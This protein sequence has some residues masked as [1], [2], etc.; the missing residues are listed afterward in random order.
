VDITNPRGVAVGF[1]D[2]I[3]V[4]AGSSSETTAIVR[5]DAESWRTV[6]SITYPFTGFVY[7]MAFDSDM[8]EEP[9]IIAADVRVGCSQSNVDFQRHFDV[10]G[11]HIATL[12][13]GTCATSV[14]V[15]G[16]GPAWADLLLWAES[17]GGGSQSSFVRGRNAAGQTVLTVSV[18]VWALSN[19]TDVG[20]LVPPQSAFA[21]DSRWTLLLT[22]GHNEPNIGISRVNDLGQFQL[23]G[24]PI[25]SVGATS[26]GL[27]YD[28]RTD[29]V[30]V[31]SGSG[32][33]RVY[34][35][36]TYNI[37]VQ[38]Q[39]LGGIA[40]HPS[41]DI[42]F[43][44]DGGLWVLQEVEPSPTDLNCDGVVNGGDL[45]ILLANW[46]VCDDAEA[47]PADLNGDGVVDGA[48]LGI[49]LSAWTS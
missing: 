20:I 25:E 13:N 18:P 24:G 10:E 45:G 44:A 1:N 3:F 29:T 35:D 31:R 34:A 11:N 30:L 8:F 47:C 17:G 2:D 33:L 4:A 23:V 16:G 28:E 5:I 6:Q 36:G 9:R 41:G 37:V 46:G 49:L 38:A 15:L 19:A 39:S 26:R 14:T 27:A 40:I 32:V 42:Y 48:D 43:A 22:D 12:S 21:I 7:G